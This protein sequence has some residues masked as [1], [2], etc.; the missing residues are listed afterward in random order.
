MSGRAST[1][2]CQRKNTA[3]AF[4]RTAAGTHSQIMAPDASASA[5]DKPDGV[6]SAADMALN[7]AAAG[8]VDS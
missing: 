6:G 8:T 3:T 4:P 7:K 1:S 2:A 5:G